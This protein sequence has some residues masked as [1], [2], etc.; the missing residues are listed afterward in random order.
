MQL[1]NC[2]LNGF[3]FKFGMEQK[4]IG[5]EEEEE[6]PPAPPPPLEAEQSNEFAMRFAHL[7][8]HAQPTKT[9]TKIAI[10]RGA[11]SMN[12]SPIVDRCKISNK[13]A[14]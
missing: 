13:V 9:P 2:N 6:A 8:F 4:P 11:M 10:H 7:G 1:D 5:N 12:T 3:K 14:I